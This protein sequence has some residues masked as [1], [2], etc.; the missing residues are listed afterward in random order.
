[1][2]ESYK[3]YDKGRQKL[4]QKQTGGLCN[5]AEKNCNKGVS[6]L[7]NVELDIQE[8]KEVSSQYKECVCVCVCVCVCDVWKEK[9]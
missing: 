6:R 7:R 1:M 4:L 3:G 8:E 9:M 2:K 5:Q